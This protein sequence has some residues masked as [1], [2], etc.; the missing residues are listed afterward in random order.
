MTEVEAAPALAAVRAVLERHGLVDRV[1]VFDVELPTAAAAAQHLGCEVGAIAN[2]LVFRAGD[3]PVLVLAS[4][5]HRVDVARAGALFGVER[6]RRADA[7]LVLAATGQQVGGCA[8]VG[9]PAPLRT[10]IDADLAGHERLWAGAGIKPAMFWATFDELVAL[11]G[12]P[13]AAIA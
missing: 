1:R 13:V 7:D 10:V 9:H 2:S 5:A 12:A 8:P 6:L 11:T 4:G 3:E